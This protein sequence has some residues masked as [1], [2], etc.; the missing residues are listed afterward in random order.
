MSELEEPNDSDNLGLIVVGAVVLIGILIIGVVGQIS[1]AGWFGYRQIMYGSGEVYLLNMGGE[2]LEVEIEGRE[3]V[4]VDSEGARSVEIVGG[5]SRVVAK[6][7]AG[8]VVYEETVFVDDSDALV[9]LTAD[10]CLAVSDLSAVYGR[11]GDDLE[12]LETLE[13]DQQVYVPG[14]KNI[15]WPRQAFPKRMPHDKGDPLWIELVACSLIEEP[16]FLRAYLDV[17]LG[18]RLEKAESKKGRE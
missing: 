13:A 18:Q 10:A 11:G 8:D 12:I 16:K 17:R 7:A 9:K 2:S 3:P 15:V 5:E 1:G 4:E 6:N 14:S